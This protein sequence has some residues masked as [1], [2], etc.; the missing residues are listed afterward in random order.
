M[1]SWLYVAVGGA[2]GAVARYGM[3][4]LVRSYTDTQWPLATF[5]VNA[6]GAI[7]I[8]ILA[9]LLERQMVNTEMRALAMVGFFGAFTT[10]ST[11]SLELLQMFERGQLALGLLYGLASLL[12]CVFG[13][14]SGVVLTRMLL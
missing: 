4:L 6:L 8:G 1:L 3:A 10:L 5:A 7:G 13:A 12:I 11:V 2:A 14:A 9:V